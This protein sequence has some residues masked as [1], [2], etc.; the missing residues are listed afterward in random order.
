MGQC[1][2]TADGR[3]DG[4]IIE[5]EGRPYAIVV[6]EPIEWVIDMNVLNV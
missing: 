6:V 3:C 4:V 1:G 2:G 5:I